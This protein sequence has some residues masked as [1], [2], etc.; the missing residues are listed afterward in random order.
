MDVVTLLI[1]VVALVIAVVAY[2]RT[3]GIQELQRQVS[4]MG[5]ATES[6]RTKTTDT[7]DAIREKMADT[8]DRLEKVVRGSAE[9]P[10]PPPVAEQEKPVEEERKPG[11]EDKKKE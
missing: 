11:R 7:L 4:A 9:G 10:S 1:A 5:P 3:G 6:V 8:L 2:A